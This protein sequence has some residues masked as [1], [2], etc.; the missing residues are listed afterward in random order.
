MEI[1]E[2]GQILSLLHTCPP[3]TVFSDQ[4]RALGA[5]AAAHELHRRVLWSDPAD[6]RADRRVDTAIQLITVLL[7][8]AERMRRDGNMEYAAALLDEALR[9]ARAT[10]LLVPFICSDAQPK[11]HPEMDARVL[12]RSRLFKA[13][14]ETCMPL[15]LLLVPAR[16][17]NG[18]LIGLVGAYSLIEEGGRT[19]AQSNSN[20]WQAS[21]MIGMVRDAIATAIS[22]QSRK[23]CVA[24]SIL[25]GIRYRAVYDEQ[26]N[27][28]E[29]PTEIKVTRPIAADAADLEVKLSTRNDLSIRFGNVGEARGDGE[30]DAVLP[31]GAGVMFKCWLPCVEAYVTEHGQV[32]LRCPGPAR[33][34]SM[35]S[36]LALGAAGESRRLDIV[37]LDTSEELHAILRM[38]ANNMASAGL[39]D[40]PSKRCLPA[41]QAL[42]RI[43]LGSEQAW[44]APE[45]RS[46]ER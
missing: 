17:A 3:R 38:L 31:P 30:D 27:A 22:W 1:S 6:H 44:A 13:E 34:D 4:E 7:D 20:D 45:P 29:Q 14:A 21:Q 10:R 32:R 28:L 5:V 8:A 42:F 33:D 11:H 2:L 12:A 37:R 46:A 39:S 18:E 43:A 16:G 24:A 25:D 15:A 23:D 9:H 41:L 40:E 26:G 36:E 35:I 19:E